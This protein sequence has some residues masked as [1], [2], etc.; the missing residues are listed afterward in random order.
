MQLLDI[1]CYSCAAIVVASLLWRGKRIAGALHDARWQILQGVLVGALFLVYLAGSLG[2]V[3]L[4]HKVTSLP[5]GNITVFLW[6]AV[7]G[8]TLFGSFGYQAD[9]I[10]DKLDD[11]RCELSDRRAARRQKEQA[12]EQR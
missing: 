12:S 11:L 3:A 4:F 10:W 9:W 8:V 7:L 1:V 2:A 5:V 6:L